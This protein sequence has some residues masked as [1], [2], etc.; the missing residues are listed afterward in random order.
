MPGMKH[1][2]EK[3]SI[4]VCWRCFRQ[5]DLWKE[6]AGSHCGRPR[7]HTVCTCHGCPHTQSQSGMRVIHRCCSALVTEAAQAKPWLRDACSFWVCTVISRRIT[8]SSS[9]WEADCEKCEPR[10]EICFF[11]SHPGTREETHLSFSFLILIGSFGVGSSSVAW[12]DL[13]LTM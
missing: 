6:K 9:F 2:G 3:K 12:I 10:H 8:F 7:A 1:E 4:S 11:W 5:L 13:E